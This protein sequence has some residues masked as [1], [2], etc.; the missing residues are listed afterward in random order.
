MFECKRPDISDAQ[1]E[2]AIEQSCGY[3]ASLGAIFCGA[4]AGHTRRLLRFDTFPP[5]EREQNHISDIPLRYGLPPEWRFYRDTNKDLSAV[6]REELRAAIRKCHQTL[7][8]GGRRNPIVAFGEFSKL[9]FI[10]YRDEQNPLLKRGEPYSFQR[11]DSETADALS[12][13]IR[14]LYEDE[15]ERE[16]N[17]F[18]E[19]INIDPPVLAK[20]VEHLEGISLK[21]TELDTKGVA[22]EEFMG[23]FFKG[24]FGQYF[25]P[26]EL[27]AFAVEILGPQRHHFIP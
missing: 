14:R 5:G 12:D 8:E 3:R 4:V 23:S 25:T 24:D 15:H 16:P 9:I 6:S 1:F 27:I 26:R 22:F 21:K 19:G 18:A 20:C 11:R 10:K 17:V 2:Q 13:R 7:W